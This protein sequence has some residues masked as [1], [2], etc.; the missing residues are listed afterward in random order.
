MKRSDFPDTSRFY[1]VRWHAQ[2]DFHFAKPALQALGAS[3]DYYHT[4]KKLPTQTSVM[5]TIRRALGVASGLLSVEA[6]T[7]TTSKELSELI[8]SAEEEF[9][10]LRANKQD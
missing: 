6:T 4:T 1:R 7:M 8:G 5:G 9:S 2:S 3:S 10:E